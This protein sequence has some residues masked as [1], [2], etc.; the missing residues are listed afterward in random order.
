[1]AS[2]SLWEVTGALGLLQNLVGFTSLGQQL[3]RSLDIETPRRL[4]ESR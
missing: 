1:M 4:S 3:L 2:P